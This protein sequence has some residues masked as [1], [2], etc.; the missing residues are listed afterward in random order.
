M[1]YIRFS[2]IKEVFTRQP[3]LVEAP[4]R[5]VSDYFGCNVFDYEKMRKYL[6]LDAYDKM[7]EAIEKG[8]RIDRK[9]ADQVASSMKAWA[10]ENGV[11]HYTH[12]FHP[13]N[14]GTA[15]KHDA[16][17]EHAPYGGVVENFSG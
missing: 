2:A 11:T 13:L 1:A 4:S 9:A 15:E 3:I 7:M 17:I 5:K 12:W 6:S 16:F 10:M 14:D 8:T